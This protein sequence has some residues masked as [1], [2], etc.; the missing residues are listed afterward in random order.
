M[1][2]LTTTDLAIRW[3][4]S[5]GTLSNWRV[6]GKGPKYIKVGKKVLYPVDEVERFEKENT[7]ENTLQ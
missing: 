1:R 6:A 4:M 7:K 5:S 2:H 3:Q